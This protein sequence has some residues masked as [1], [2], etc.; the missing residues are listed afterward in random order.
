MK[1][2]RIFLCIL[3]AGAFCARAFSQM[4]GGQYSMPQPVVSSGGGLIIQNNYT[5]ETVIGQSAAGINIFKSPYGISSG[6]WTTLVDPPAT[7]TVNS[8]SPAINSSDGLCTLREGII[9]ANSNAP[10]GIVAGECAAGISNDSDIIGLPAGTY[11]LSDVHNST[12]NGA[13]GLP[14]ISSGI[15]IRGA[16][17]A[18]TII[19][20][21]SAAGTPD[22]R[23]FYIESNANTGQLTLNNVTVRNG[24]TTS[25][26]RGGGMIIEASTKLNTVNNCVFSNNTATGVGNGGAVYTGGTNLSVND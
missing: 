22:F 14:R 3:L 10:S 9:A 1:T 13:N 18:A 26:L 2:A 23:L 11:T 5:L 20:R 7:I 25:N 15:V 17:A 4:T 24:R 12:A 8:T 6:F 21:S 19:E 16:G